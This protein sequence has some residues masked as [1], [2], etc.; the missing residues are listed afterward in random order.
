MPRREDP[1]D[2]SSRWALTVP[3]DVPKKDETSSAVKAVWFHAVKL[4]GNPLAKNLRKTES[5]RFVRHQLQTYRD[6]LLDFGLIKTTV[7][8]KEV[9]SGFLEGFSVQDGKLI[10]QP[11]ENIIYTPMFRSAMTLVG[12][13]LDVTG[14]D[15][16]VIQYIHSW[17][18]YLSKIPL[19]RP[20]LEKSAETAWLDRQEN[21]NPILATENDFSVVRRIVAWLLDDFVPCLVG[22]HGPGTVADG[23]KTVAEKNADYYPTV[24]SL[25]LTRFHVDD[26]SHEIKPQRPA[27]KL[28]VPKDISSLRTITREPTETQ[29]AQ[30]GL[31]FDLYNQIDHDPDCNAGNFVRFSDQTPS[32]RCAVQGSYITGDGVKPTTLDLSSA[33]DYLSVDLV[34]RLFSGNIL[35][36]LMAGRTWEC[37]VGERLVELAMYGGM[38]SALTFPVQSLIF[39][40]ISI[41]ATV[42]E[43]YLLTMGVEGTADEVLN[44]Y[45]GVNGLRQ[46]YKRLEKSIR[47]YGDDICVPDFAARRT[48]KL[49]RAFGL[50]VNERKSFTGSSPVRESCGIYA[51]AGRDITPKR[52]RVPSCGH[53]LDASSFDALRM[54]ANTAFHMGWTDLYRACIRRC[55]DEPKFI[56]SSEERKLHRK[57]KKYGYPTQK[58]GTPHLLFEE[59]RGN[60]DYIGFISM[61]PSLPTISL[62]LHERVRGFTTFFVETATNRDLDSEFYHLTL[63]Y[64]QM[65]RNGTSTE[66]HASIAKGTRLVKRNA[67]QLFPDSCTRVMAWGWAP[68]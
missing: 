43:H 36:Y 66:S 40:A 49:L 48:M 31:K 20:D 1:V 22:N 34:V 46:P 39:T 24:Q 6:L 54:H 7:F 45:L 33:S 59:Y 12:R 5:D 32:Q 42:S 4:Y 68:R 41:Y 65:D 13:E 44:D 16:D 56:S 25:S 10:Y 30:Q 14:V 67:I 19:D 37:R 55:R 27:E 17:L 58:L 62:E 53:L 28:M 35:H 57:G 8:F 60:V 61:R 50:T 2:F 64:R 51:L 29:F 3:V 15:G 38:G 21:P 9:A 18:L 23:A 63:S 11:D 26:M 52:Y 47:V